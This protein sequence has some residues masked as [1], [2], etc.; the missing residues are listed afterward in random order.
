MNK[1]REK[2][3]DA[4][5]RALRRCQSVGLGVY[6]YDGNVLVFPQPEGRDH[7]E[8]DGNVFM[9]CDEIGRT[10]YVP[11]LDCDGGAGV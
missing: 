2:A 5:E 3:A 9:L 8:W 10:L 6:I 7:P 4:L 11:K 1:E